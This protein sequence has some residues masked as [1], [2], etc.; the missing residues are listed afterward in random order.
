ME[1]KKILWSDC[2]D[3]SKLT[4]ALLA[5]EANKFKLSLLNLE[6]STCYEAVTA[7]AC[8]WTEIT[9]IQ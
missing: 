3:D 6:H 4:Y 7:A 5:L 1:K 2:F 8:K 9:F